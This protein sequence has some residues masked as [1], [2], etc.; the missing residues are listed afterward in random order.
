MKGTVTPR[1]AKKVRDK[2]TGKM[3]LAPLRPYEEWTDPDTGK[4]VRAGASGSTW[5]WRFSTG[6]R[7]VG[8]RRYYSD[9]GYATKKEC[10]DAL[11]T[12]MADAGRGDTRALTKPDA[13]L[14]GDYLH[15]WLD[16][17]TGLKPSTE[18]GYRDAIRVWIARR[19]DKDRYRLTPYLGALVLADLTEDHLTR[20]YATLKK[21]GGR[22][23][24]A[25]RKAAKE[26]GRQPVGRPLGSRSIHLAH[27]VLRMALADAV[28]ARKLP[29]SPIER[30]PKRQ[31][32]TH[33]PVKQAE[34]VWTPDQVQVF[35][36]KSR[37]DRLYPLLCLALD[38]GARRGEL[39]ALP[40]S[41]LDL[42]EGTVTFRDNRVVVGREI[43]QGET[44]SRKARTVDLDG[45]T[46]TILRTWKTTQAK[47]RLL[48]G[49]SWAGGD[50][51]RTG[52]VFTAATGV[53]YRPD[54]LSDR[55]ERLQKGLRIP[56][57]SLHSLRHT[58]ATIALL[59][60][61][62]VHVVSERLGHS[63]VSTTL[64]IYAHVI[65]TQA[66]DAARVI[67]SAIYGDD[68]VATAGGGA[69]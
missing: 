27:T 66:S 29:F 64:D 67:G 32:P 25:E 11:S 8:I 43:V 45:R 69:R 62:A 31:R 10:E 19:D 17:R 21:H 55:F 6:S 12:A 30:I 34:R 13:T 7:A 18:K 59:R 42:E 38:T 5:T 46:V 49:E 16:A 36:G 50:P 35:L 22:I 2:R 56:K 68:S 53:P 41:D 3:R 20:L 60:G 28:E 39:A 65:R 23:T 37:A 24:I 61:V 57:R 1:P 4:T 54:W 63:K 26:E 40:W 15:D 51:G 48:A 14:V 58:S 44:K 47:E 52:Y 33:T 9:G